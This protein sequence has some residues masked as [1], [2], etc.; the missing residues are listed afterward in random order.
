MENHEFK[1]PLGVKAKDVLSGFTGTISYRVQYITGCDQYGLH[2]GMDKEGKLL[3]AQQFDESRI[4]IINAKPLVLPA[5]K[6]KKSKKGLP[7]GP[8]GRLQAA[9]KVKS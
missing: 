4:E 2:P 8:S 9:H 1:F 7:G 3:D 6:E 5:D